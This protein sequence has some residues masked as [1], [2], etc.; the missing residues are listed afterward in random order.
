MRIELNRRP[1][2]PKLVFQLLQPIQQVRP[3]SSLSHPVE[4]GRQLFETIGCGIGVRPDVADRRV[5]GS[6]S[7]RG[8]PFDF[9]P[10]RSI[11][12]AP[13]TTQVRDYPTL[14]EQ[15]PDEG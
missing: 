3:D 2:E 11:I 14:D 10:E 5:E 8:V 6:D 7:F 1:N 15:T 9:R 12:L 13:L 4:I